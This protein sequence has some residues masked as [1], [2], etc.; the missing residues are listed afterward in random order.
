[1]IGIGL[2]AQVQFAHLGSQ[3]EGPGTRVQGSRIR[4]SRMAI[5]VVV[6]LARIRKARYFV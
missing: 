5:G 4:T 3:V 1:M 6:V 2:G